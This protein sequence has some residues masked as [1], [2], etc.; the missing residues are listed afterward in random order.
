M[1]EI[2][3]NSLNFSFGL[4]KV[5]GNDFCCERGAWFGRVGLSVE[6]RGITRPKF[7]DLSKVLNEH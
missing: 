5:S 6:A 7:L 4:I 3:F 1:N 2:S